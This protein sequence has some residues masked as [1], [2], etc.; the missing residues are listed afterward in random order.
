MGEITV[1]GLGRV[2]IQGDIPTPEEEKAI[3]EAIQGSRPVPSAEDFTIGSQGNLR[4]QDTLTENTTPFLEEA[5]GGMVSR[6]LLE[7]IGA[8]GGMVVGATGGLATGPG[9]PA[10]STA[11]AI[12]GGVLGAGLGS[13][14][15]DAAD[16]AARSIAG[17]GQRQDEFL[18][19]SRRALNAMRT[20]FLF[21]GG[22]AS[23]GPVIRAFKPAV[24]KV[25]GVGSDTARR[26]AR[27]A[28]N[29]G[30]PLGTL[31]ASE[32]RAVK[33]IT[34]VL[35]VFPFVG[36]PI[37]QAVK[38]GSEALEAKMASTLNELA[39]NATISDLGVDL[40]KAATGRFKKFRRIAAALYDRFNTLADEASVKEIIPTTETS[41]TASELAELVASGKIKLKT[42]DILA[43]PTGDP[44][45]DFVKQ[46]TSLPDA[47]TAKQAR[48]LQREL[49]DLA[50]T[51]QKDGFDLSRVSSLKK[52]L[53][54]DL[55]NIITDVLPEGEAEK[56]VAALSNANGFYAE[57]IR[58][59]QTS[60]A[61]KFA[62]VDRNIFKAGAFKAGSKNADETFETVFNSR[63][64]QALMDLKSVVGNSEFRKASRKFLEN[65][66]FGAFTTRG[67]VATFDPDKF[68]KQI[69]V[70]TKEGERGLAVMLEGSGVKVKD[71]EK[72]I[73]VARAAGSI[74]IPDVSAFVAR[75]LTLAGVATLV[76]LSGINNPI[77]TAVGVLL[78]RQGAK[79]LASPAHLKALTTALKD[80]V[81]DFQR[82]ALVLR[83]ARQVL[84]DEEPTQ[85]PTPARSP[86]T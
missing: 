64:P 45:E 73:D 63:S 21:S 78:A 22:A 28:E 3:I 59:F 12:A 70:G 27:T 30:I 8:T 76:T 38:G 39:P 29:M 26:L 66:Y 86:V 84:D 13:T 18:D 25:L 2:R 60:T 36:T 32:F 55:N 74:V 54:S 4:P 82:R 43:S 79:I 37:R 42:G 53:E 20:E 56:L 58:R 68:A 7:G 65:S 80:T 67:K 14:V 77:G 44:L 15:F 62:Q 75:R 69:G 52:A 71:I 19:P 49:Q 85:T 83:V 50:T 11:G 72:F 17:V 51:M 41:E 40:T 46:L 24:G 35:G 5:T 61:G 48:Q 9:A 10:A 6:G 33:G 23:L 34:K 81:P 16:T 57:T 1:N 31:Q 47:I